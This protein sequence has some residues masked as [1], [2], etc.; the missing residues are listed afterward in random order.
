M[1]NQVDKEVATVEKTPKKR[2]LNNKTKKKEREKIT[3]NK[4]TKD[5]KKP[6]WL[7]ILITA[8][9]FIVVFCIIPLIVIEVTDQWCNLFAGFFNSMSPG[10]CP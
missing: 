5:Q 4:K 8:L 2:F 9:A 1:N 6:S 10:V 3:A 7:V